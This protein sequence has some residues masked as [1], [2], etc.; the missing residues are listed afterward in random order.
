AKS[1][2]NCGFVESETLELEIAIHEVVLLQTAQALA[3]LSGPHGPNT[4]H[5]LELTLRRPYDGVEAAEIGHDPADERLRHSREVREDPVAARHHGLI[6]WIDAA[7]VAQHLRK[8]P[9]LEQVLVAELGEIRKCCSRLLACTEDVVIADDR[10]ALSRHVP[11][12][13]LK[14]EPDQP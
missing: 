5:R 3:D 2:A 9:E 14:L 4:L 8:L 1:W 6:E 7:V 11:D 12:E 10:V 13:L